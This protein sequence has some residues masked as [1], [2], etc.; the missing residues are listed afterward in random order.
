MAVLIKRLTESD[1][2][3]V[4]LPYEKAYGESIDETI[5]R[6]PCLKKLRSLISYKN[7][8]SLDDTILDLAQRQRLGVSKT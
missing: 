4:R 2:P 5:R 8:W 1:S 6:Q 3:I 7:K